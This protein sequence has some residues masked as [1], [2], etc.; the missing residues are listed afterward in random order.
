MEVGSCQLT[1][2]YLTYVDY[3]KAFKYLCYIGSVEKLT[4]LMEVTK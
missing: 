4:N 1:G 2:S 3:K